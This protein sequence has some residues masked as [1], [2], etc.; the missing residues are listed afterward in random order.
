M[1]RLSAVSCIV[2]VCVCIVLSKESIVMIS[3]VLLNIYFISEVSD[4][5]N[6]RQNNKEYSAHAFTV[7]VQMSEP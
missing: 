7:T 6:D 5:S 1:P 2:S 4:R 3:T